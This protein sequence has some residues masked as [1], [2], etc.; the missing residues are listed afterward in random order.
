M[1]NIKSSF[2]YFV[3]YVLFASYN[4][5]SAEQINTT[6]S[7]RTDTHIHLYD[8]NR[9]GSITFLNPVKHKKVYAPHLVIEF[10]EVASA[11]GNGVD[12]AIVVEASTRREDNH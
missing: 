8:T 1:I 12:Y 3:L 2:T 5:V 6:S 9:E 10:L 7:L 4:P 11:N